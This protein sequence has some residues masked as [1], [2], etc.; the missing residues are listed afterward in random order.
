MDFKEIT[1][2]SEEELKKLLEDSQEKERELRFKDSNRQLKNVREIRS[3][4]KN[5]ARIL[6]I[7]T[8][9]KKK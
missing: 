1:T 6:T 7:L 8:K 3:L 9:N 4:K 2:K 5:I